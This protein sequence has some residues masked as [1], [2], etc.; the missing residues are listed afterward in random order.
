M[1]KTMKSTK[2][3]NIEINAERLDADV[4]EA[5]G[6]FYN[7]S[8][9]SN[10]VMGKANNYYN[11]MV[12]RGRVSKI[13]L[14]KLCSKCPLSRSDKPCFFFLAVFLFKSFQADGPEPAF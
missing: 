10:F 14:K 6:D 11:M 2:D 5:A 4:R 7:R 1:A 8:S 13:A 3:K 9:I 12:N